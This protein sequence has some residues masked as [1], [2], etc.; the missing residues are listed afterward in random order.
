[1]QTISIKTDANHELWIL[2]EQW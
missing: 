1:M 2:T